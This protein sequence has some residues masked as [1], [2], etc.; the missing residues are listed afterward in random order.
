MKGKYQSGGSIAS[1]EASS[2]KSARCPICGAGAVSHA[3]TTIREAYPAEILGCPGCGFVWLRDP[4]WL[5]E[6]YRSPITPQDVGYVHR[7]LVCRGYTKALLDGYLA[8][9][10]RCLDFGAGYGMFVRLMRD[11]GYNFFA[12]DEH[13]EN[14]FAKEFAVDVLGSFGLITAFEVFEHLVSPLEEIGRLVANC[15]TLLFSTQ[16]IPDP[17]PKPGQWWY[18]GLEHGQ[19]LAFYSVASLQYIA[20][21]HN[22]LFYTDGAALHMISQRRLPVNCLLKVKS[23][24]RRWL[25]SLLA[26]KRNRGVRFG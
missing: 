7:N 6:A 26:G 8:G 9:G 10:E 18:Y 19:H 23:P 21:K 20:K 14:L 11:E 5:A 13:T 25:W 17:V 16:L 22:R 3:L 24:W 4:V 1:G 12:Y 2:G 15:E